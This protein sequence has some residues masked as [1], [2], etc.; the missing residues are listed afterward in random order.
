MKGFRIKGQRQ[1]MKANIVRHSGGTKSARLKAGNALE[2]TRV[3]SSSLVYCLP[4]TQARPARRLK[5][6]IAFTLRGRQ[7][8]KRS[9]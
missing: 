8:G 3:E 6:F 5:A 2:Q 9:A 7:R 1:E 4:G